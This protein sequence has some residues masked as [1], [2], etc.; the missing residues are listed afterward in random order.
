MSRHCIIKSNKVIF[1][2]LGMLVGAVI[3]L[4]DIDEARAA[5]CTEGSPYSC[6]SVTFGKLTG[7]TTA[8]P[9]KDTKSR[10]Y[11]SM[12][13]SL[14]MNQVK[15]YSVSIYDSNGG[16]L[17]STG[18]TIPSVVDA[19][20]WKQLSEGGSAWGMRWT[21]GKDDDGTKNFEPI[22]TM[23]KQVSL[24]KDVVANS[25]GALT[26]DYTLG[27]GIV[28]DGDV[29]AGDYTDTLTVAVVAQPRDITIFDIKNMQDMTTDICRA[30]TTPSASATG[31]DVDGT[32]AGDA[33]YVPETTLIDT[34]GG[35]VDGSGKYLIR[36]LADGNCWMSQNLEL[37][38]LGDGQEVTNYKTSSVSA[39]S[40]THVAVTA[41]NYFG[42]EVTEGLVFTANDTDLNS[43]SIW[44]PE[45]FKKTYVDTGI[46][47]YA[48]V[49]ATMSNTFVSDGGAATAAYGWANNGMDGMRSYN[50]ASSNAGWVYVTEA[51]ATKMDANGN[52]TFDDSTTGQPYARRGNLYN[53]TAATL[54]SSLKL[55]KDGDEAEDSICPRGWQLPNNTGE[56]SFE[57]LL[58]VTYG[59]VEGSDVV[60]SYN[61]VNEWPLQFPRTGD[62]HRSYGYIYLRGSDGNEWTSTFRSNVTAYYLNTNVSRVRPHFMHARGNGFAIRCVA[63]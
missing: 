3:G 63:R 43:T 23:D 30:T 20:S 6:V 59:L 44:T 51:D 35:G 11:F 33:T 26:V 60:E 10:L 18:G 47:P 7:D 36:K 38:I 53:W 55:T 62:Y 12:P 49:Y 31:T 41:D 27:F 21:V 40:E 48:K 42:T 52:Y 58:L 50:Y 34:R 2:I 61:K 5:E 13:V 22:P 16:S 15:S 9:G 32:H 17:K 1:A 37:D 57:R 29:A 25:R 14:M 54:G 8:N 24:A 4:A 28:V 19:T 56:R 39:G 46:A 45:Y